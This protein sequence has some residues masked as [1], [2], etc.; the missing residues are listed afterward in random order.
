[1]LTVAGT[2]TVYYTYLGVFLADVAGLGSQGLALVV[3]GFGL[4]NAVGTRFGG[5]AADR[6]SARP[7]VILGSQLGADAGA[8]GAAGRARSVAGAGQPLAE[9]LGH[10][11]W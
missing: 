9:L 1:V 7:T 6:L 2:F 5:S 11:P 8:A 3:L 10:L 4:A